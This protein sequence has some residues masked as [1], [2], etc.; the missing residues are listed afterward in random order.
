MN[1]LRS[2]PE[3]QSLGDREKRSNLTKL[4]RESLFAYLI[5]DNKTNNVSNQS[6]KCLTG[7]GT[8]VSS[9]PQKEM[10]QKERIKGNE[11]QFLTEANLTPRNVAGLCHD[12]RRRFFVA[13]VS[14]DLG[15]FLS[16]RCAKNAFGGVSAREHARQVQRRT[17]P[18]AKACEQSHDAFRPRRKRRSPQWPRRQIPR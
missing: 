7:C 8:G 3:M 6:E 9:M 13:A 4:H 16:E 1:Q 17:H 5:T 2:S 11:I 15:P 12:G 10:L 14:R 18:N